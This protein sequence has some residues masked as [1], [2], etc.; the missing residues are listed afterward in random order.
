MEAGQ[1]AV[2]PEKTGVFPRGTKKYF[3]PPLKYVIITIR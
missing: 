2:F 1:K 3:T